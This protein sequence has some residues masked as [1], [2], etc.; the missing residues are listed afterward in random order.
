MEDATALSSSRANVDALLAPVPGENPAGDVH[1]YA[2]RLGDQ[3]RELRR[4]E[5]P[6]DYDDATRPAQLKRADWPG[7]VQ[8]CRDAL[9]GEAKDLRIACHLV[10]ALV[11]TEGFVGLRDGLCLVGRLV[12]ECWDRLL[13]P[14]DDGDLSQR[15]EPLANMLDDPD[16]G[17]CFPNAVRSVPL[18]GTAERGYG[19]V[20]WNRLRADHEPDASAEVAPALVA[21]APERLREL[22]AT[23]DQCLE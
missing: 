22:V 23:T 7:I 10:E 8:L 20:Q 4:E 12:D 21:T 16:R 2:Y 13:P 19:L 15:G 5:R 17:V 14:I 6:D 18:F 1:A 11:K 3:V 9:V